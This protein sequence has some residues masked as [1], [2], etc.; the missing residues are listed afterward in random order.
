MR[1]Q[2]RPHRHIHTDTCTQQAYIPQ[3]PPQLTTPGLKLH[4]TITQ[5]AA[6]CGATLLEC[7]STVPTPVACYKP[8]SPVPRRTSASRLPQ[9]KPP[10]RARPVTTLRAQPGWVSTQE[11]LSKRPLSQYRCWCC[12]DCCCCCCAAAV[13]CWPLVLAVA[14]VLGSSREMYRP[15]MAVLASNFSPAT[16]VPC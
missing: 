13:W 3:Q 15:P 10:K 4:T 2:A 16:D 6:A 8:Q 14:S 9:G 11:S 1:M 5:H 12:W 7:N